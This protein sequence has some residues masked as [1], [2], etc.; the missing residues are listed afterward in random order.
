L[1]VPL[2]CTVRFGP[3]MQLKSDE[4]KVDFLQRAR[5]AVVALA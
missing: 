1:P 3:A 2:I 4:N 5:D